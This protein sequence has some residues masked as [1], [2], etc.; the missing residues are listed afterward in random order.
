MTD[1]GDPA[2]R[3][4]AP[5]DSET[6]ARHASAHPEWERYRR[7]GTED[8]EFESATPRVHEAAAPVVQAAAPVDAPTL[9]SEPA[10]VADRTIVAD[11]TDVPSPQAPPASGVP[12]E[13][14]PPTGLDP[15]LEARVRR[16]L[17]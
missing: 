15:A 13:W 12:T 1:R 9:S 4:D 3:R 2:P 11:R 7:P 5:P 6:H 14:R 8:R 16:D 10:V 17:A